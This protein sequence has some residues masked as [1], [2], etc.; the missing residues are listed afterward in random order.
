MLHR[1]HGTDLHFSLGEPQLKQ[2]REPVSKKARLIFRVMLC[3]RKG[4][5]LM[6]RDKG[7][8]SL[9]MMDGLYMFCK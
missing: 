6:D 9:A 2:K 1:I 5:K 7:L 4:V 3:K 8:R